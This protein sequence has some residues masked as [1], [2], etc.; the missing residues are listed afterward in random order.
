MSKNSST[1]V[2]YEGRGP[3]GSWFII[4]TVTD[5]PIK[6]K[7]DLQAVF[8]KFGYVK[9]MCVCVLII[10]FLMIILK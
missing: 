4:E 1:S 8:K 10:I 3:C 2:V 9:S 6:T 7:N 5:K